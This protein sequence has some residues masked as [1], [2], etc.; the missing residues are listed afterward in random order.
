LDKKNIKHL[1]IIVS[2]ILVFGSLAPALVPAA[3]AQ[4]V[5]IPSWIKQNAGWWSEGQIGDESFV[6][7][8]QYLIKEDILQQKHPKLFQVGLNKMQDGGQTVKSLTNHL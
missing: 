8:L 5:Y 2:F 7:G 4:K 1:S 6:Q 3:Q